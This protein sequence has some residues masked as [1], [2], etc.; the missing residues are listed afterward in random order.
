MLEEGDILHLI[1]EVI[2]GSSIPMRWSEFKTLEGSHMKKVVLLIFLA[3]ALVVSGLN[4]VV[5]C[6]GTGSSVEATDL[7][8][9]GGNYQHRDDNCTG[10]GVLGAFRVIQSNPTGGSVVIQDPGTS[11]LLGEGDIFSFTIDST[12]LENPI[13]VVDDLGCSGIF[14]ESEERA[15]T[16]S[17]NSGIDISVGDLLTVC[18]DLSADGLCALSYARTDS[19]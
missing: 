9:F 10:I 15:T 4:A 5:G 12:S 8:D 2:N 16:T 18:D 11:E 19:D 6:G 13:M 7:G 1:Y 14:M 3:G 17:S